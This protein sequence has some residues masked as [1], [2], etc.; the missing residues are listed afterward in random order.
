[1]GTSTLVIKRVIYEVVMISNVKEKKNQ[2]CKSALVT[3]PS[4]ISLAFLKWCK[5]D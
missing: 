4:W 5:G 3:S 2:L 1:M